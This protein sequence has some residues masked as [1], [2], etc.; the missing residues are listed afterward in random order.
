[1]P[2]PSVAHDVLDSLPPD[3]G[4]SCFHCGLP[5]VPGEKQFFAQ[6]EGRQLLMCCQGCAAVAGAISQAGLSHYYR[7]RSA[8]ASK[9]QDPDLVE[10]QKLTV[11]DNPLV[12]R[13]FVTTSDDKTHAAALILEGIHCAACVWLNEQH[14]QGLKGVIEV[15]VNYATHRA[16]IRWDNK[17]ILLSQIM[18]A[19]R[20]IGYEARPYDP[21]RHQQLMSLERSKM[22]KRLA[23]AG[24]MGMQV[25]IL[26]VALYSG[27]WS[28]IEDHYREYFQKLSLLLTMPVLLYSAKPFFSSAWRDV[29][30]GRAGMD[31]PV[32]VGISLAFAASLLS[33]VTGDGEVYFDSICMFVFLLLGTRT[34]E[35][36]A[37]KR[38]AD[39]IDA[40]GQIDP[41]SAIRINRKGGLEE[42]A[43]VELTIGDQ[44]IVRPGETIP[45]DGLIIAGHSSVDEAVLTGEAMPRLRS[46]NDEVIGGSINIDS[47]ITVEVTRTGADATLSQIQQLLDRALASKPQISQLADRISGIFTIS[48]L[49]LA[50]VVAFSWWQVGASDW[51]SIAVS[52]LVVSCPCALS[53][54]TPAAIT[55]TVSHLM[56][57]G[58][59]LTR[60]DTIEKLGGV[61]KVVFDKTGTLTAGQLQC[62]SIN[63]L[64][65]ANHSDVF[66][67][68]VALEKYSEHP[69]GQAI[70]R[71]GEVGQ[72]LVVKNLINELGG[73]VCGEIDNRRYYVGSPL[74]IKRK[75]GL[76]DPDIEQS[77]QTIALLADEAKILA[78]FS[79]SDELRPSTP[80]LIRR[81]KIMGI[82]TGILS[83]DHQTAVCA[84]ARK[85]EIHTAK[86]QLTPQDKLAEIHCD[87][88]NG[89]TVAMV[90]DGVNDA[91]VLAGANVSIA[92]PRASPL[93]VATADVVLL[94]EDIGLVASTIALA[95]RSIQIIRQN[96]AW[97]LVYNLL[98]L[99]AAAAGFVPPWLAAIGMSASSLI[100]IG[101]ALRLR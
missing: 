28:G 92:V 40:I 65:D 39:A 16:Q 53:L 1:M 50:T 96:L 47:A 51:L 24:A 31:V 7:Q 14:L 71:Y 29:S 21:G 85:L 75:V 89:E 83:G 23:V 30:C 61:S 12:Q 4:R 37:R 98:A 52:V 22:L 62:T 6:I 25:M 84:V 2:E 74:F 56:G 64:A 81:L 68:T 58:V 5:L 82:R 36:A 38:A 10:R 94:A 27:K 67:I 73:G 9:A 66:D 3:G 46:K 44:V 54:A 69:V 8:T 97:A 72:A 77:T 45:A 11:F 42:I 49:F 63:T 88:K 57:K 87:Q 78:S 34:L 59:L 33:V 41:I 13:S 20:D 32:T 55:T 93:A 48:V 95:R 91:P 60:A 90:G 15:R 17:Q 101:N 80:E 43:A 100:V 26:A 76:V 19:V 18:Q 35:L 99:P 79:F 70:V 86:W